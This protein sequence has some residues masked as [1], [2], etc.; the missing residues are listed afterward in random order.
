MLKFLKDLLYNETLS[1]EYMSQCS[2]FIEKLETVIKTPSLGR[3]YFHPRNEGQNIDNLPKSNSVEEFLRQ[4]RDIARKG[5]IWKNEDQRPKLNSDESQ[6]EK[7]VFENII[8]SLLHC[9]DLALVSF[10]YC[11]TFDF[12]NTSIV[13]NIT[14]G[15][16]SRKS[17]SK[18]SIRWHW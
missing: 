14:V 10:Y 9:V 7:K 15:S 12:F 4:Q 1:K 13:F 2:S 6:N 8:Y 16:D 3:K 17:F 11:I 18:K 5:T